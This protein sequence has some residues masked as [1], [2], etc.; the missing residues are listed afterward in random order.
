MR[1]RIVQREEHD[2]QAGD[3]GDPD[4]SSVQHPDRKHRQPQPHEA[5]DMH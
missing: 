2:G 1:V 5:V 4:E 3:P